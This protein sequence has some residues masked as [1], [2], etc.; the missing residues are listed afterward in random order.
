MKN[1]LVNA[2]LA[3]KVSGRKPPRQFPVLD[4]SVLELE[5]SNRI[6]REDVKQNRMVYEFPS[7]F[8]KLSLFEECRALTMLDDFQ[9]MYDITMQMLVN[10]DL[11][12]KMRNDDGTVT[13]LVEVHVTDRFQD[14]RGCEAIDK[15]PVLITWLAEFMAAELRKKYPLPGKEA[16][17]PATAEKRMKGGKGEL[18][19]HQ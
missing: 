9:T 1:G 15:Y 12:I 16:N 2:E 18:T 13:T 4:A 17:P 3:Q 8:N 11:V 19:R 10:K 14:L 7:G 5:E 6:M